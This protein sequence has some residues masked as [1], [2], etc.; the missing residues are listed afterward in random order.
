M[1]EP[2]GKSG[3]RY[4]PGLDGLRAVAVIA[5][6]L[7]HLEVPFAKGGLLGV[8]I[9]FT[10]SGY[11][12]TDILLE[13]WTG[14]RLSLSQFWLAR[15][16]RLLPA[17]MV[18]LVV[19]T[20]WVALGAPDQLEDLRGLVISSALFT[21]NWW[22]IIQDASYFDRFGPVSPLGHLW[23]LAIEEQ[24]Y[25]VWPWLLLLG[26]RFIPSGDRNTKR[27]QRERIRPR[28]AIVTL[29]F[30]L[31]SAILMAVLYKPDFDMTRT[32]EGTDTRAFGLLAGAALAMMWPSRRLGNRIPAKARNQLDIAG[33][34]CFMVMALL[35]WRTDEYSAFLYRGGLVLLTIATVVVVAVMAHPASRLGRAL[36]WEPLRW[37]GVRSY[38][39]YL[40]Q[41]PI[42]AL[43]TP[44]LDDSFDPLRATLQ[45]AAIFGVSAL[46]WKFIEDP[47]RHGAIGRLWKK[48][49]GKDFKPDWKSPA[50][51]AA[52][53]SAL[54]LLIATSAMIGLAPSDRVLPIAVKAS[55]EPPKILEAAP[56]VE[57]NVVET[58]D[59][60][61]PLTSCTSVAYIGDSTSVG[62]TSDDYLPDPDDQ[63]GAQFARV[64]ATDQKFDISGA[65]SIYE[66]VDGAPNAEEAA[67][68]IRDAGFE[69]C[70]VFGMG[71]NDT[72]NQ[73]VG[74]TIGSADRIGRMMEVVGDS[75]AL[76]INVRTLETGGPYAETNMQEWN[77]AL[78]DACES[79]PN[80]R[81]W[82]WSS[83]VKDDW[84]ID[85]GIHFTSA[86]YEV[87]A[88]GIAN[89]LIK[90]F[91]PAWQ[92][93]LGRPEGCVFK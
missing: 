63:L 88:R 55:S 65:R 3:Q 51:V 2:I 71:T 44:P 57:E 61:L 73:F 79:Y 30:A 50:G 18:M 10:L 39:I 21:S 38:G 8:G 87:R 53:V 20:A 43:T 58:V 12:I 42:I 91:P 66:R 15:A 85:D 52:G 59:G 48:V 22:T 25:I 4:M 77:S 11:L 14:R 41:L 84:F 27:G 45:V 24:F 86:G 26:L 60:K 16:R 70:W 68:A 34:A 82:D 19:V 80:M 1:P 7:Y 36:G 47:V 29:V 33:I 13:A 89:A 93:T 62:L 49:R 90:A 72:A 9:F 75:P 31:I 69:G 23:S 67:R 32:Y 64:G 83:K 37:I 17:L 5:V 78:E 81:I 35:I 40:W 28:L 92:V 74:S 56:V 46:S 54:V 6:I 76:W